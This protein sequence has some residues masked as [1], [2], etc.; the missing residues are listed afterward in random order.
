MPGES[1]PKKFGPQIAIA[2][3]AAQK[4]LHLLVVAINRLP[5]FPHEEV[6]FASNHV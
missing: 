3:T 6:P 4:P 2:A 5:I 1:V